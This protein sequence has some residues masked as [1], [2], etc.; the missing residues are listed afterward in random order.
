MRSIFA[1]WS[2]NG[3]ID[4]GVAPRRLPYVRQL[5]I[6]TVVFLIAGVG[7]RTVY[8]EIV[9]NSKAHN[10]PSV[11]DAANTDSSKRDSAYL[12]GS[13]GEN[14]RAADTGM[15][16]MSAPP[17]ARSVI[18]KRR[19]LSK[20]VGLVPI[21]ARGES[22]I[23]EPRPFAGSAAGPAVASRDQSA[24]AAAEPMDGGF[25]KLAENKLREKPHVA[26]KRSVRSA[27]TFQVY[28]LPDG[29]QVVMRRPGRN[30]AAASD[31]GNNSFTNGPRFGRP[32]HVARPG[33][34]FDAP[35]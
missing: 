32:I 5:A 4:Y 29:R 22:V 1:I 21:G 31:P 6:A 12:T 11:P 18:T 15:A 27:S 7:L 17:R 28:E 19:M 9:A 10:G 13:A 26:K 3:R 30:D 25:P 8:S 16:P 14:S 23:T 35:F 20:T 34:F 24:G 2:D 33:F